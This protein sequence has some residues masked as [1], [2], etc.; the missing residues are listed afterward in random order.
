[1]TGETP[2]SSKS[3][4]FKD[5]MLKKL[6][7]K[8]FKAWR[9]SGDLRLAPLT[10]LFG[11]NSAGKSSLGHLLLCL[12]QTAE[13]VDRKIVLELGNPSARVDLGTF[14]ECLHGRNCNSTL[15]FSLAWQMPEPLKLNFLDGERKVKIAGNEIRL[16]VDVKAGPTRQPV[17]KTL[18]YEVHDG[19]REVLCVCQ[20]SSGP[21]HE[22]KCR[23][24]AFNRAQDRKWPLEPVEKFYR[25]NELTLAAFGN[26]GFIADLSLATQ[27]F[28]DQF[29]HLGALRRQAQRFYRWNGGSPDGVGKEGEATVDAILAAKQAG[30]RISLDAGAQAKPFE[31]VVASALKDMT[32]IHSFEVKRLSA[33]AQDY[34][35]DVKVSEQSMPVKIPDVGFGVSQILPV[36]VQAFYAPA[37]AVVWMEQPEIH[38]H[39]IAQSNLADVFISAI[40]ACEDGRPKNVQLIIESHSEN[41]LLRLQ[42][43]VAEG[44]IK[45]EE[46][47]VYFCRPGE[48][49]SELEA[50]EMSADGEILNWPDNC[51]GG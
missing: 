49:G 47:A 19:G 34:E 4:R 13:S 36:V 21:T 30:R 20:D 2:L 26:A 29:Y 22:L 18:S 16:N 10:V 23:P 27:N 33:N 38:L 51:F 15:S 11:V 32:L 45:P 5:P 48:N 14:E 42:R 39:P 9:D 46:L 50:M 25:F 35:V 44:V 6:R 37:N 24:F 43:R 28:F 7:V 12:K 1:M 8:N 31:E 41:L 3:N 17:V 40:H